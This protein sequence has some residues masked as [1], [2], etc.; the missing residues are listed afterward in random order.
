MTRTSGEETCRGTLRIGVVCEDL[1]VV[2]PL[3]VLTEEKELRN[4]VDRVMLCGSHS[5]PHPPWCLL[6]SRRKRPQW[7]E[8][9]LIQDFGDMDFP[10]LRF[11]W[12]EILLI[13][14]PTNFKAI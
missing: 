3:G 6:S 4:R 12:L 10:S 2:T 5:F 13:T 9:E 7:Q 11:I 1:C 8:R 14:Q